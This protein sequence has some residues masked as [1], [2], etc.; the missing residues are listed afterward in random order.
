MKNIN[1]NLLNKILIEFK[2]NPKIT[3]DGLAKK[4][5]YSERTI[6]RYIKILKDNKK[7]SM[8]GFGRKKRWKIL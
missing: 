7:I 4:Y 5:G 2:V 1:N 3:E 8:V 6:R